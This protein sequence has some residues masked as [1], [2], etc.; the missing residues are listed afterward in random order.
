M[1]IV[2]ND[3]LW[4]ACFAAIAPAL[5]RAVAASVLRNHAEQPVITD[6]I[7]LLLRRQPHRVVL[8]VM[9][10][11]QVLSILNLD[12]LSSLLSCFTA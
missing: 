1:P 12:H 3:L 2:L 4:L 11:A 9:K 8:R 7:L 6:L 10:L 5:G